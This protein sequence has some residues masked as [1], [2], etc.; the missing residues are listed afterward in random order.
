MHATVLFNKSYMQ[1]LETKIMPRAKRSEGTF[2]EVFVELDQAQIEYLNTL[3]N[4]SVWIR[5]ALDEKRRREMTLAKQEE[6]L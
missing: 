1:G 6:R 4:P 3:E 2:S 5:R